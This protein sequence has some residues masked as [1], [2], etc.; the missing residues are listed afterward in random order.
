MR[1]A[2]NQLNDHV[3]CRL[4]GSVFGPSAA[5]GLHFTSRAW[6][7]AEIMKIR[8][9]D[10]NAKIVIV[11]H[12]APVLEANPP[13]YR[14]GALAPAFVSDMHAEI[15]SWRPDLWVFGHT[16]HDIDATVG[17]TRVLSHQRG[18]VGHEADSLEF[19][20]AAIEL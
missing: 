3:H 6:L 2:N 18:Y 20:P 5:R 11:T 19:R 8:A 17:R 10:P 4:R 12:H 9:A 16:H 1:D 13:Q 15:A 14:G 7:G